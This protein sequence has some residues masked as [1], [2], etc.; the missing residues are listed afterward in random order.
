MK[1]KSDVISTYVAT[2]LSSTCA[3]QSYRQAFQQNYFLW[4]RSM[5]IFLP[6]TR[7]LTATV[8]LGSFAHHSEAQYVRV[9]IDEITVAKTTDVSDSCGFIITFRCGSV[10][11]ADE[12]YFTGA[13]VT[14]VDGALTI[15]RVSPPAPNDYYAIRASRDGGPDTFRNIPVVPNSHQW[16][17]LPNGSA[18]GFVVLVREQD[19]AQLADINLAAAS[20]LLAATNLVNPSE[21]EL[22]LAAAGLTYAAGDVVASLLR[23]GDDTIGAFT[24]VIANVNNEIRSVWNGVTN[25]RVLSHSNAAALFTANGGFTVTSGEPSAYSIR[26]SVQQ[27]MTQVQNSYTGRCLEVANVLGNSL[28][29]PTLVQQSPCRS[30]GYQSWAL[31]PTDTSAHPAFKLISMI[32]SI[33]LVNHNGGRCLDVVGGDLSDHAAIQQYPCHFGPDQ[34]WSLIGQGSQFDIRNVNSTKCLD[35][36]NASNPF[37][38]Q[39]TCHGGTNQKWSLSGHVP[40]APN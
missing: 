26:A 32:P 33:E 17:Y 6:V 5:N 7:L 23:D 12:V 40:F 22:A 11:D 15:P 30:S 21:F 29:S 34:Q 13:A 4:K 25:T 10:N 3:E 1:L 27:L 2:V 16:F 18:A 37:I 9:A 20:G 19:N 31:S 38:Q 39:F 14:T 36:P 24:V 35:V 28:F 8:I